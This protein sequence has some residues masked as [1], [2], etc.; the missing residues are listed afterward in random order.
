MVAG[1]RRMRADG[2]DARDC[3]E[4]SAGVMVEDLVPRGESQ[5]KGTS[6][7]FFFYSKS[8]PKTKITLKNI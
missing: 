8:L 4:P 1:H 3:R 2:P 7:P 6:A 5:G